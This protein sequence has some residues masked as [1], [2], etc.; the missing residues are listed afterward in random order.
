M[1]Q[2]A[3]LVINDNGIT[4]TLYHRERALLS[5]PL[6]WVRRMAIEMGY[7]INETW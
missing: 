1:M 2:P 3:L 4:C 5:G 6:A 7:S